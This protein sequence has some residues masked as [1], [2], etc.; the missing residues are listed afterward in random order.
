MNAYRIDRILAKC[1]A[2]LKEDMAKFDDAADSLD[3]EGEDSWIIREALL[4][5]K[6]VLNSQAD[7]LL[8]LRKKFRRDHDL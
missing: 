5:H 6:R 1:T 2:A 7:Y 3:A 4:W 8:R